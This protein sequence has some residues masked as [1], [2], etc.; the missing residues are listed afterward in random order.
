MLTGFW[1]GASWNFIVWGL[2]NCVVLLISQELEPFYKW[3]HS[4]TKVQGTR[5]WDAFRVCRTLLIVSTLRLLDCYRNVPLTWRMFLSIF[6]NT[7]DITAKNWS[8]LGLTN[9]DYG[10]I[11]VAVVIIF[12]V[13][14]IQRS[15]SVREKIYNLPYWGK[16]CI[17][18]GLFLLV[19]IFGQYGIGFS[20]SQF[21]YNQF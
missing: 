20:A 9:F 1:H 21:I 17:W 12:V 10:V 14:L 13:S 19:L 2:G 6:K 16:F 4:K 7:G 3:F 11:I 5:I 15:G 18:F 8:E